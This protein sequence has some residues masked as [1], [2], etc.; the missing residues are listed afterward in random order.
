MTLNFDLIQ[1]KIAPIN[2]PT[3]F[4]S[5]QN[6]ICAKKYAKQILI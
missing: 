5:N 4:D 6:Y 1:I 3:T 2:L